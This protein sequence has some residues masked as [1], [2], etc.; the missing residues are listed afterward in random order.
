MNP[1]FTILGP[2]IIQKIYVRAFLSFSGKRIPDEFFFRLARPEKKDR[3]TLQ[4]RDLIHVIG[5]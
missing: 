4:D 3:V 5:G 2:R 1:S